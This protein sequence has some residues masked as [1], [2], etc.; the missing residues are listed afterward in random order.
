MKIDEIKEGSDWQLSKLV[1]KVVA[2]GP[3]TAS[4]A[5]GYY[6]VIFL[7]DETGQLKVK[8]KDNGLF[9]DESYVGRVINLTADLTD[10]IPQG[11]QYLKKY[12]M[13]IVSQGAALSYIHEAKEPEP[14]PVLTQPVKP[15]TKPGTPITKDDYGTMMQERYK[16][17][18]FGS[19]EFDNTIIE[20]FHEHLRIFK[21]LAAVN[22]QNGHPFDHEELM[23][24]K[25]GI[26]IEASRAKAS[27]LPKGFKAKRFESYEKLYPNPVLS[28]DQVVSTQP[29]V[30]PEVTP[31]PTASTEPL[32]LDEDDSPNTPESNVIPFP[33]A[34]P[35][36]DP[37]PFTPVNQLDTIGTALRKL[38]NKKTPP[39]AYSAMDFKGVTT[40]GDAFEDDARRPKL[41]SWAYKGMDPT[42]TITTKKA[43]VI[44]N[45]LDILRDI[46][47]GTRFLIIQEAI[48]TDIAAYNGLSD[49]FSFEY[50]TNPIYEQ[51]E[52]KMNDVVASLNLKKNTPHA[53]GLAYFDSAVLPEF[54]IIK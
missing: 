3:E 25:T 30:D 28:L 21:I 36:P 9:L 23:R 34:T 11:V 15:I 47:T 49:K 54:K 29:E 4:K 8:I 10:T 35:A 43:D 38:R 52:N 26:K 32:V 7:E 2:V 39:P 41:I 6:Q 14:T 20:E 50:N 5:G 1:G 18:D 48:M 22:T 44:G 45:I 37:G 19:G 24:I 12:E 33:E 51:I 46:E 13:A 27:I 53:I 42:A 40:L 31:E 17:E 16:L